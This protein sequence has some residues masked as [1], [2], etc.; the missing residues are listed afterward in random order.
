MGGHNKAVDDENYLLTVALKQRQ[1]RNIN[2]IQWETV[3]H[4]YTMEIKQ[5][6]VDINK[7]R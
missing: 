6:L 7:G 4:K 2:S 5:I 1:K 3:P